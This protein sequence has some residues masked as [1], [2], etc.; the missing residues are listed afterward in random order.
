MFGQ[1]LSE[2]FQLFF[3]EP[4]EL[5][6]VRPTDR[7]M[8]GLAKFQQQR[9]ILLFSQQR[10]DVLVVVLDCGFD[11]RLGQNPLLLRLPTGLAPPAVPVFVLAV[12]WAFFAAFLVF[13]PLI[14]NAASRSR[15]VTPPHAKSPRAASS[16]FRRP[17]A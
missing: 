5:I 1:F 12:L 4:V 15:F 9:T 11:S 14:E 10:G 16:C 7:R 8:A 3:D 13:S 2:Q 17:L 6:T